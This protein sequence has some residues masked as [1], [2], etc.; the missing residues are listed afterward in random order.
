MPALPSCPPLSPRLLLALCVALAPL[1]APL[2]VLAQETA[3]PPGETAAD[4]APEAT[5]EIAF[6]PL[7]EPAGVTPEGWER[8]SRLGVSLAV[9]AGSTIARDLSDPA[10][11]DGFGIE[12]RSE[13]LGEGRGEFALALVP[14]SMMA[15][16]GALP[17]DDGFGPVFAG[18]AGAETVGTPQPLALGEVALIAY[19]LA[20]DS[21]TGE[22]QRG[23]VAFS[24]APLASG[25]WLML[26]AQLTG[27]A[28]QEAIG[29][30]VASL[31]LPDASQLGT[32]PEAAPA[33][34]AA[35]GGATGGVTMDE[36]EAWAAA[37]ARGTA[38]AFWTY[39]KAHPQGA[40]AAEAR[41][42]SPAARNPKRPPCPLRR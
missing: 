9:P 5:P 31:E 6:A 21:R 34:Q 32:R 4:V 25:D 17:G 12:L 2:P 22:P 30:F 11:A 28:P 42:R 37:Q 38:S 19:P 23:F 26:G 13:P 15:R 41:D 40:H 18:V 35:S 36:A 29:A 20:G 10:Q 8:L 7:P 33:P 27:A 39:L 1:S 24:A 16:I 3:P 14:A